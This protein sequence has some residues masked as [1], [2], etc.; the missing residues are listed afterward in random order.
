MSGLVV[1]EAADLE[2][3][4]EAAVTRA[5]RL[6]AAPQAG[7]WCDAKTSPL[8]S[9]WTFR[10]LAKQGAFPTFKQGRK[11]I[12]RR[13]DVERYIIDQRIELDH[14]QHPQSDPVDPVERLIAAGKLRVVGG[15]R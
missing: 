14:E 3:R 13:A 4:I 7:D 1:I 9:P 15:G 11:L 10:R 6:H 12:A 2:K 5:L 8:G